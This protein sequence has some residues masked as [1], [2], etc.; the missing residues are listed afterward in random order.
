MSG[1]GAAAGLVALR[2]KLSLTSALSL[3]LG[4]AAALAHATETFAGE[5]ERFASCVAVV[6]D[7]VAG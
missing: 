4:P 3:G 1:H 5:E 7:P 2:V 6:F